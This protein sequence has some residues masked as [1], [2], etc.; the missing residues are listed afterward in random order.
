[1][2]ECALHTYASNLKSTSSS[3]HNHQMKHNNVHDL[4]V[5]STPSC[6]L[7]LLQ[8]NSLQIALADDDLCCIDKFD[9]TDS[10]G[11]AVAFLSFLE[12]YFTYLIYGRNRS[13][14]RIK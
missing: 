4:P 9:K 7:Q 5:L 11:K 6:K 1:M 12:V 3:I 13:E 10:R 2:D 14:L 8:L